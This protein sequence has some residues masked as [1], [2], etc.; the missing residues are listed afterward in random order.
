MDDVSLQDTR[1]GEL[2]C[3]LRQWATNPTQG[4]A[5][6]PTTGRRIQDPGFWVR[7]PCGEPGDPRRTVHGGVLQAE[8]HLWVLAHTEPDNRTTP[9]SSVRLR[10]SKRGTSVRS[11]TPTSPAHVS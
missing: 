2:L 5:P 4:R 11:C 3:P 9:R 10:R 6:S 7:G 8:N 1:L